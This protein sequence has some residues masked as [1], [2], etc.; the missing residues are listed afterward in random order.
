MKPPFSL[1]LILLS[2]PLHPGEILHDIKGYEAVSFCCTNRDGDE[3]AIVR[4]FFLDDR[5]MTLSVDTQTLET[6]IVPI[7]SPDCIERDC[8]KDS[9]YQSLLHISSSPPYPLQNDGIVSGNSGIFITTD[10][11]PSS[12]TGFERRLYRT[13]AK[14]FTNP[15]PITVFVTKRWI[16]KHRESFEELID[17][18][19]RGELSIVWGNHTANHIY[20]RGMELRHNFILSDEE[21]LTKDILDLE[22]ELLSIGEK[23]SIFFRAP[24]LVSDRKSIDTVRALGLITIGADTWIAKGEKI[25][26]GSIILVHGNLNEKRGVDMFLK[27]IGKKNFHFKPLSLSQIG[28]AH[29][30]SVPMGRNAK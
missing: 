5:S 19:D 2:L 28:G 11:C 6:S 26:E 13:V 16:E 7:P 18:R 27:L 15:V 30:L 10:L 22:I 29:T 17:M 21:R 14:L 4:K 25:H 9:L 3:R 23:P 1:F 8:R 12:K 20:H 24:G